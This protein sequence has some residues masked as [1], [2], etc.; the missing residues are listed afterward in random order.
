MK[1]YNLTSGSKANAT[2]IHAGNKR[3]LIDAGS[4]KG[5]LVSALKSIG[6]TLKDID[7]VLVT[8]FHQD[9]CKS[10]NIFDQ[11][12][13]FSLDSNH[14]H[15]VLDQPNDFDDVKITPF[16]LSHDKDCLGYQIEH[17]EEILTYLTDTGYVKNDYLDLIRKSNYLIMEFN[18]D[19]ILLN[20]TNRPYHT[21]QRIMSDKG[22][23]NN[24][25]AAVVLAKTSDKLEHLL[26][27]HIS[28]QANTISAI[29]D[30]INEVFKAYDKDINFK[31]D[32]TMYQKI[33][34]G[35]K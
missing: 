25:D 17:D 28:E 15:L 13:I 27:A 14:H 10:L 3:I 19:I 26:V 4:S 33:T 30:K 35:G 23:L 2:L 11:Q 24:E 22:H 18:H 7:I 1:F 5:Y 12:I 31:I 6:Y 32:Y 9:H 8:H 29:E 16:M 34:K 20:E 21:K